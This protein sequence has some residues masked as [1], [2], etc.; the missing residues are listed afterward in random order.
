MNCYS[1]MAERRRWIR[2]YLKPDGTYVT[3]GWLQLDDKKYYMDENGVKLKDTVTPDGF[4]VNADGEKVSYMP[5]WYKDGDNWRYIQKNGYYAANSWYQDT[6]GKYYYFN[7]GAVMAANTT[8]PDGYYVDE[9]GVWDG[10]AS[11]VTA[12]KKPW[13]WRR[14]RLGANRYWLEVQAGRWHLSDQ[15]LETGF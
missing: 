5:G 8:T 4:Y 14:Q 9:N 6:D 13:T 12:R 2:K 15:C 1:R 7:M 10:K 11:T 3:N